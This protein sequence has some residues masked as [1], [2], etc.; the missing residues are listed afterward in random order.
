MSGRDGGFPRAK[1]GRSGQ[2]QQEGRRFGVLVTVIVPL[3]KVS[4]AILLPAG[5]D[6]LFRPRRR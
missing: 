5:S 4:I 1:S 6:R 3:V 2:H